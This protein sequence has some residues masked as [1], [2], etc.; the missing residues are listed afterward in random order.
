VHGEPGSLEK[1]CQVRGDRLIIVGEDHHRPPALPAAHAGITLSEH[2]PVPLAV[3][4]VITPA[5]SAL[6]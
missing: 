3:A 1:R 6:K 4:R 5:T 2:K